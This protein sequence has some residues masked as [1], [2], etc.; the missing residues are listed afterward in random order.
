MWIMGKNKNVLKLSL[1]TSDG[2]PVSGIYF[3]DVEKFTNYIEEKFG[4]KQLQAAFDGKENNLLLS[5]VYFPKINSF[6]G[7]DELQFEI[8]FFQ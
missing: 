8:Q 3:G 2:M 5:V 1:V 4:R 6:R 7:V